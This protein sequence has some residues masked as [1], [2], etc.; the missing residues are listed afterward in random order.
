MNDNEVINDAREVLKIEADAILALIDRIGP[1]FEKAVEMIYNCKGR[2]IATG[3][4]KS[5]IVGRKIVATMSSTGTPALFLHPVEALH[6]DLGVVTSGDILLALSQS[7]ETEVNDIIPIVRKLG[8][9]II[10]F[11]GNLESSL[12]AMS[13]VVLDVSVAREACPLGLAPTASTTAAAAMGD[14][15]AVA[16]IN[17][18]SFNHEDFKRFHPGGNL[19]ERLSVAVREV[20]A[21]GD[22]MPVVGGDALLSEALEIMNRVNLGVL[23]VVEGGRL[24]GIFTDGDLRRCIIDGKDISSLAVESVMTKGPKSISETCLAVEA[25]EIMQSH[26]ITVLPIV[27]R[28]DRLLGAV[29]LHS[30]LGKGKFRFDVVQRADD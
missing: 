10:S 21:T 29:H 9:G 23:L 26:E 28:E 16:L 14:A 15:L 22:A 7:G 18:R 12:A 17:R 25:L 11:T 19:G 27:D 8:V 1:E 2:V 30:L 6:G 4:G 3:I 24:A 20:M 13:D 5:G